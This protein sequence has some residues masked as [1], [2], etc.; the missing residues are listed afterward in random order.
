MMISH[1][2]FYLLTRCDSVPST[3]F[4]HIAKAKV[5]ILPHGLVIG[6]IPSGKAMT[7]E[8]TSVSN[9]ASVRQGILLI[10][11][12]LSIGAIVGSMMKLL[13]SG[14][15]AY[16]I[17]WFRFLGFSLLILPIVFIRLGASELRVARPYMQVI[18]GITTA[19]ATT[20]FILGAR[21]VDL[22]DAVAITY[23]YPFFLVLLAIIFLKEKVSLTGWLGVIGG[24]IGVVLV[25]RP[26]F[27]NL[28][29]GAFFS[30][31]CA[32]ILS[33]QMTLN[34][35]LGTVSHPLVTATWG[36]LVAT[37][38]SSLVIPFVWVDVDS[39]QLI[40]IGV[41]VICGT[42][43]QV[44]V[45]FAFSKAPASVLAPF[46]YTE[47]VVSVF[48]GYLF[49]DTWPIWVSW[50]GIALIIMSGIIVAKSQPNVRHPPQRQ[51]K[52]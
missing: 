50:I 20:T 30:L 24:F 44:L 3:F 13:S 19:L 23:A 10:V 52:V 36:A 29:S 11:I 18:R 43:N 4:S 6:I 49:F 46:T 38:L 26:G 21:S 40:W 45:V 28:N 16:Q 9:Q 42:F 48:V 7:E 22:A 17:T 27:D 12:A 14:I 32:I 37:L 39:T 31:S 5:A 35:K 15:S 34:R 25:I 51:P 1:T 47:I 41:M 33:V 2:R 8:S